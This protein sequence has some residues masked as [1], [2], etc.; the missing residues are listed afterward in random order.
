MAH[1]GPNPARGRWREAHRNRAS[2]NGPIGESGRP[3]FQRLRVSGTGVKPR[4]GGWEK[5]SEEASTKPA[6]RRARIDNAQESGNSLSG[7]GHVA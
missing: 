2:V 6:N 4:Y 1:R 3:G 5:T 7:S